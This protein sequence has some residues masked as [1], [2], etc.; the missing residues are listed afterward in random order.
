MWW[1]MK[2]SWRKYGQNRRGV[3]WEGIEVEWVSKSM[4]K[5]YT[6]RNT[7]PFNHA[8]NMLYSHYKNSQLSCASS[9]LFHI[10]SGLTTAYSYLFQ[11]MLS[12]KP[13]ILPCL[14]R[15]I[16]HIS[17]SQQNSTHPLSSSKPQCSSPIA[18]PILILMT[19][20]YI[21]HI[22]SLPHLASLFPYC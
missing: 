13:Y 3:E 14:L 20:I 10:F 9:P 7:K 4:Q 8:W 12:L 22:L 18:Q 11:H 21:S 2:R 17:V 1:G 6:V 16:Y 15:N 19:S 5:N